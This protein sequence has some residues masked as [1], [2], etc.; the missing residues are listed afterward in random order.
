MKINN[1]TITKSRVSIIDESTNSETTNYGIGH[2]EMLEIFSIIEKNHESLKK[3]LLEFNDVNKIEQLNENSKTKIINSLKRFGVNFASN[4]TA[5]GIIEIL[6]Y[7][8]V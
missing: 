8:F 5:K 4:L 6:K 7:I 2:K 1:L 3:C